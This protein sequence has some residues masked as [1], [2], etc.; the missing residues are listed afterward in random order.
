MLYFGADNGLLAFHPDS[1]RDNPFIPP[2]AFTALY[3]YD[4]KGAS[5]E[6]VEIENITYLEEVSFPYHQNT[7]AIELAA[8]SY[9][10]TTKNQYAYLIEGHNRPRMGVRTGCNRYCIILLAIWI[11]TC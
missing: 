9:N 6:P 8:L 10:K 3:Y 11:S 1:L 4:D 5:G 7:L 2:I